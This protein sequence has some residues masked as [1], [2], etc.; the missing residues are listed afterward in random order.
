MSL[1]VSGVAHRAAMPFAPAT[2]PH[3]RFTLTR[4]QH[5]WN[6]LVLDRRL[7][8]R[9]AGWQLPDVPTTAT[10]DDVL[11][12]A[13]LCRPGTAAS[14]VETDERVP[15]D[16]VLAA[17]AALAVDDDLAAR[18]VLQRLLPGL[19]AIARRRARCLDDH[20]VHTDELLGAAW[21]VIRARPTRARRD[22]VASSFLRAVE[23]QVFVRHQRR[24]LVHEPVEP[25][26]LD[27]AVE[28]DEGSGDAL[29]QIV[30]VLQAAG[31]DALRD[32]DAELIGAL[33]RTDRL[34]EVADQLRVSERTV[35]NHREAM[36]GRL[37]RALAA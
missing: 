10:L 8:E 32:G 33:L 28:P 34:R 13:G 12:A 6:R 30:A 18:V 22:F 11:R 3:R 25:A 2:V 7:T 35:R 5:D 14:S 17:L 36:V 23:H 19:S 20:L 29:G 15:G 24:L 9:I 4:L 26:S 27:R 37:R 31:A 1:P 16:R 21:A